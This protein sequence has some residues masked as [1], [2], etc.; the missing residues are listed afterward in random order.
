MINWKAVIGGAITTVL[1]VIIIDLIYVLFASLLASYGNGYP[2]IA[3]IKDDLWFYSALS[4]YCFSMTLGGMVTI[5]FDDE[6]KAINAFVVG[7]LASMTSVW[8]MAPANTEFNTMSLVF[9]V[10]GVA[11]S[12]L[13]GIWA[14]HKG[15]GDRADYLTE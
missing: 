9:L 13:G 1:M 6:R 12:T 11:A 15:K 10:L 4:V 8:S 2:W 7:I 14:I 5:Y 3:A